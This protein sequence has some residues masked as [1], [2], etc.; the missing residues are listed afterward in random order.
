LLLCRVLLQTLAGWISNCFIS[1]FF[2]KF[3]PRDAICIARVLAMVWC[4]SLCQS[5]TRRYCIKTAAG[6]KLFLCTGI[7]R[8]MPWNFVP[9]SRLRVFGHN[10]PTDGERDK[11]KRQRS[12]VGLTAPDDDDDVG[13]GHISTVD[14]DRRLLMTLGVRQRCADPPASVDTCQV[15]VPCG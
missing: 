2:V 10:S 5:V 7:P 9:N 14:D 4:L 11:N 3:Y 13:R 15:L 6:I 12:G 1:F 8:H